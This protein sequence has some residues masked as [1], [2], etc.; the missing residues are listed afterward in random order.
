MK[1]H[2]Y[3]G[4]HL[5]ASFLHA[6]HRDMCFDALIARFPYAENLRKVDE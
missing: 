1:F 6:L 3:N 5:Q 4:E 2:I